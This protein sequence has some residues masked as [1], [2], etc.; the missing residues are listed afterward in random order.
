MCS[1]VTHACCVPAPQDD[2]VIRVRQQAGG[3]GDSVVVV[4]TRSRSRVGQ[5]DIGANGARIL[6][7][8]RALEQL[9]SQHQLARL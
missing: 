6:S 3:G 8:Q 9:L 5:G 1:C 7:F 4:D 2:V